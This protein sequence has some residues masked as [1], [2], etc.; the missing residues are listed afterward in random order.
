MLMSGG[1]N[2]DIRLW[3]LPE[4]K[5]LTTIKA[6]PLFYPAVTRD[7]KL[8][9]CPD[10]KDIGYWS[11]PDGKRVKTLSGHTDTV[12]FL[13]FSPDDQTLASSGKDKRARL[14]SVQSGEMACLLDLAASPADVK[15]I[16]VQGKTS[17][18][19][20]YTYTLPCGSPIPA[21]AT[22]VCNCVAGSGGAA[23]PGCSC[24]SYKP[25]GGSHYWYPN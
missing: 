6:A 25:S 3:S 9:A 19:G 24:V 23:A 17:G 21:G 11:L 20:S 5:L 13:A 22:C 14:W 10:S 1:A 2:S 12:N 7:G 8:M 18:G 16:T 15:G 4:G